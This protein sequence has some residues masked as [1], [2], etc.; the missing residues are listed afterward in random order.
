MEKNLEQSN[1]TSEN[2]FER[3]KGENI[4]LVISFIRH[5]DKDSKGELTERGYESARELGKHKEVLPDGI[6]IYN[7]PFRRTASTVDAILDGVEEQGKKDKTFKT[8][9][10]IELAPPEWEHFEIIAKKGKEAEEKEGRGGLFRYI[11][12]E[13]LAQKDLNHWTS[14]LAFMIDR[15]R[16]GSHRFYEGSEVELRHITH[17]VV[18]GDFL[19]KVAVFKD[20]EGKRIEKVDF[21]KL[22][23]SM[24]FLEGFEFVVRLDEKGNEF[25]KINF[26][27][28]E[29]EVD[30]EKLNELVKLFKENPYEGRTT[31]VYPLSRQ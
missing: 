31:K 18:I 6:K 26:R 1:L 22:G 13:P 16:R 23:G 4:N 25:H 7:S 17:D 5:G 2:N 30:E 27:G 20:K 21:D 29:L 10:R 28:Q 19:R 11:S 12:H 3:E 24:N 9:Q 15:Y 8:R 14:A